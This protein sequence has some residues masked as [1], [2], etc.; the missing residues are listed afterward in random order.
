VLSET[1]VVE[2]RIMNARYWLLMI[3]G[4]FVGTEPAVKAADL[5]PWIKATAYKIPS[6]LTN[7]ESG[8]FS[9]VEGLNG[10]LYIGAAK[11]GVNAYLVEFDEATHAMRVVVD[12]QKLI[13]STATGFAAQAK[14]HTR[15]NVG[16]SGKI[17]CGT[18][19]GYPE[20]NEPRDA[21][22]GGYT[23]VY[24]PTADR[25]EQFGIAWP[26]HGIIS[27]TPDESRGVAYI[28]TC[29]DGRP[30][31]STHFMILDLK[32]RTY[33]DLGDLHHSYAFIV[34]DNRGRAYHP[35][36]GGI[37]V[38]YD[39]APGEI[40]QLTSTIDSKP[41]ALE[42]LLAINHPLNW[43]ASPDRTTLF[44]VAMSGNQL[45]SYDLTAE[46]TNVPG[47]SRGALLPGAKSTDCRAMCVGP[48]GTVWAAVMGDFGPGREHELH[49]V[50]FARGA[51][52]P[53]DHGAVGIANPDF[54]TMTDKDGKPKPWHHG[55]RTA[56]DGT[57]APMY[58]M[59]IC[60]GR[61]GSV[62]MTTIAPF[63]LLE[64]AASLIRK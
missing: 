2:V 38:R 8:Y 14:F 5:P 64:F 25:A 30:D 12:A 58:H 44:C 15:N 63:V 28:S 59:A 51:N 60:E 40:E 20:K 26:H 62:Y 22:P 16:A 50:S 21:Y 47:K 23:I 34:L 1:I 24:D 32:S 41:A 18:K 43:D 61:N 42:T 36:L 35:G 49:L 27:V 11:Y 56:S 54:T 17:Y 19:Q 45:Y 7:Q 29:D 55:L 31:E 39:P 4:A 9:L 37:I 53:R 48:S 6:E 3:L 57:L 13:G 46:G 33:R 52:A 10:R